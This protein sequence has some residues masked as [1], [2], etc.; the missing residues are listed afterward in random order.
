MPWGASCST[1]GPEMCLRGGKKK[2]FPLFLHTPT[3]VLVWR[4][5]F[6]HWQIIFLELCY[7]SNVN[8]SAGI[9]TFLKKATPEIGTLSLLRTL[10]PEVHK[11]LKYNHYTV[12]IVT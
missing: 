6:R 7:F 3:P 1:L 4:F 5:L 2:S 10:I 12:H 9:I 11:S 8:N